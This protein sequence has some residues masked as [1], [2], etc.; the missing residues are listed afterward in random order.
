MNM[1]PGMMELTPDQM[2]EVNGGSDYDVLHNMR[3]AI[4]TRCSLLKSRGKTMQEAA[5]SL[6]LV[7]RSAFGREEFD[8]LILSIWD[9]V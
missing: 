6:Y 3:G 9:E 5:D 4:K 8:A 7:Y 2:E 1:N